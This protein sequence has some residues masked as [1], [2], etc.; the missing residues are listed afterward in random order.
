MTPSQFSA[1]PAEDRELMLAEDELVCSC[2]NLKSV[3]SDPDIGLYP[4]RSMCYVTAAESVTW[5]RL[6][7]KHKDNEP[8]AKPH[9]LDGLT[10]W[11]SE[12]DLTPDDHF[13]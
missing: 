10:V 7:A 11:M 12:H 4:Q 13:V 8:G 3:C 2:G 5:R 1:L 9:P 6:R